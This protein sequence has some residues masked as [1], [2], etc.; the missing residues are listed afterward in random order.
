MVLYEFIGNIIL[1]YYLL[2]E[3]FNQLNFWFDQ[4]I[5]ILTDSRTGPILKIM[6]LGF[7]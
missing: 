4:W 5:H 2:N 3:R 6:P 1:L 7:I